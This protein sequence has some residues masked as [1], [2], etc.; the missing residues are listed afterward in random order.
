MNDCV[1][2]SSTTIASSS[3][4]LHIRREPFEYGLLPF[5]N[6][7][8]PDAAAALLSLRTKLLD[9]TLPGSGR[10][11]ISGVAHSLDLADDHAQLLFE[12]LASIL[13]DFGPDTDPLC[14]SDID[15]VGANVDD[16]ILFLYLQ[17]YK[18]PPIRPHKDAASVADVWPSTSAFDGLLSTLSP[19]QV[20]TSRRSMPSQADE[21]AHQLAYVQKHLPALL[22][23]LAESSGDDD[24][25]LQV[26]TLE[27]FNHLGMLLRSGEIG[28]EV[29]PLSQAAPFFANSD[30]DM[31]AAPV[32][33]SQVLEWLAEHICSVSEPPQDRLLNGEADVTMVDA[34]GS[35]VGPSGNQGSV[36]FNG[37]NRQRNRGPKGLT[38]VDGV[39]RSCILK[40]ERDIDGGSVKVTNCHDSVVYILAPLKYASIYGCSDS[41]IILGAVGKVVR[42]EHCERVQ[43]IVPSMRICIA[44]CRECLFHLAVNQ[45]PLILG[46]NHNLQVAPYN[47]FYPRLEAHLAQ[48]GIDTAIN[49]W[50]KLLTVGVLDPHDSVSHAAGV[51]DAQAEGASI[52]PPD[53]Y[54]NYVIPKWNDDE[55]YPEP[56]TIANPFMFPKAYLQA[57]QQRSKSVESL[58]QTLKT[59]PID[60]ARKQDL[61]HVI[62]VHFREWLYASGNIRQLYEFQAGDRESKTM[63]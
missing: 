53:R 13:P 24:S 25:D 59:V 10:I 62:H 6:L 38:F 36:S 19:L 56:L 55:A 35:T 22:S 54:M 52:L 50:D 3:P 57:L 51:A 15:S 60:E 23:L 41:I 14:R 31:P 58:R 33:L 48:V 43:L 61:L 8:F 2:C 45:R 32:S 12:T 27:R 46:E 47:T 4:S 7:I 40:E 20:R 49:R 63:D 5:P 21:E 39:A 44:N 16:L 9:L 1:E 18:K 11:G 42:I 29:V 28:S 26:L 37:F 17:N 34:P 30:P